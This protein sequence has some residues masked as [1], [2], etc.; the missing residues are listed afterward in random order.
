MASIMHTEAGMVMMAEEFDLLSNVSILR[1]MFALAKAGPLTQKEIIKLGIGKPYRI[2]NLLK[3]LKDEGRVG[4]VKRVYKE[5][6]RRPPITFYQYYIA[7]EFIAAALAEC[8]DMLERT[9]FAFA[10]GFSRLSKE[11]KPLV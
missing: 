10:E 9:H 2:K 4:V 11:L 6:P 8:C 1:I 5:K 3:F 7:D